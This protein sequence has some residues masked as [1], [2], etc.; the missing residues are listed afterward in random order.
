MNLPSEVQKIENVMLIPANKLG[1]L[2]LP[3]KGRLESTHFGVT[4]ERFPCP[5]YVLIVGLLPQK[6]AKSWALG[7]ALRRRYT[8][9]S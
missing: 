9:G 3:L 1:R 4:D 5:K 2:P 7:S 6:P 8:P